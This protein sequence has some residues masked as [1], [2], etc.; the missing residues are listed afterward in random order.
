MTEVYNSNSSLSSVGEIDESHVDSK[1]K[2]F[3]KAFRKKGI[4][5]DEIVIES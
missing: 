3:H 4:P 1:Y 2:A 5:K